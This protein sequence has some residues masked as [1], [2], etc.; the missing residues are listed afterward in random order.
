ML[1]LSL[2]F[3]WPFCWHNA[4]QSIKSRK[5]TAKETGS[6]PPCFLLS[7]YEPRHDATTSPIQ[8]LLVHR[9]TSS[10]HVGAVGKAH[11]IPC[12]EGN[13]PRAVCVCTWC[14]AMCCVLRAVCVLCHAMLVGVPPLAR[15]LGRFAACLFFSC[16]PWLSPSFCGTH[17]DPLLSSSPHSG[18]FLQSHISFSFVYFFSF[19]SP[20]PGPAR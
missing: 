18:G 8:C 1:S 17:H 20:H 2:F 11:P 5:I 16:L 12:R 10:S 15:Q 13:L 19:S 4:R 9:G 6:L 7:S 3:L 14:P